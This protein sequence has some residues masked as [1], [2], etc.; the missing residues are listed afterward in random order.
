MRRLTFCLV[1]AEYCDYLR[2][3]DPCVPYT[4]DSKSNRPF[5]GIL[6]K[7]GKN[8]YYAPLSSPKSKHLT[9]KSQIDLIKIENG[10]YG[11]INL[12]NM[13]PI[14]KNFVCSVNMNIVNTDT[15]ET[16][17]YKTLLANQLTWCNA[18]KNIIFNRAQKLYDVIINN[19]GWDTLVKRCCKFGQD[20]ELL[21]SYCKYK[22]WTA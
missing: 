22:N 1:D 6:L 8:D 11:V 21:I 18:N 12:N 17:R 13:I 2:E 16:V 4:M 15:L 14:H 19:F 20:E 10:K 7:I 5:V 9:M 3:K